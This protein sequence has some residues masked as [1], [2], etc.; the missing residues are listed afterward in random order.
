[1]DRNALRPVSLPAEGTLLPNPNGT[2]PTDR[3]L[4]DPDFDRFEREQYQGG[5]DLE[6]RLTDKTLFRQKLQFTSVDQHENFTLTGY[7]WSFLDDQRTVDRYPWDDRNGLDVFGLDNQVLL[8]FGNEMNPHQL[9][10][11]LDYRRVQS[12]WLFLTATMAPIDAYAPVYGNAI[13][14]E[15]V[16]YIDQRQ[17]ENQIGLYLQDQLSIGAWRITTGLRYDFAGG[18]TRER[19]AAT[20]LRQDDEA[21]SGRAALSYVMP[22]G[23]VPY[24]S[25]ATS[26]E[27][28]YGLD[29]NGLP[30]EPTK[31]KQWEAGLKYQPESDAD[32]FLAAAVFDLTRRN[33]LTP[34]PNPPASNPWGQI[35]AGEVR[36]RGVEL[37]AKGAL[38]PGLEF[39]AAY[40]WFDSEITRSNDAT[41]GKPLFFTPKQQASFWLQYAFAGIEGLSLGAGARYRDSVWGLGYEI[42]VPGYTLFDAM[43]SY[44]LPA[45]LVRSGQAELALNL[46]NATDKRYVANCSFYEGCY[47]GERGT[48]NASL[49]YSW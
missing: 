14:D 38:A 16:E 27:P 48:L 2:L 36:I 42:E 18:D 9:L 41:L 13:L 7:D 12:D 5:Y 1:R 4:G 24:L 47:Y 28:E 25:Y 45:T 33:V 35:Q 43:L 8:D 32:L 44:R 39:T 46:R 49:R 19:Y 37:E 23:I 29:S 31:G 22:S 30:F 34:D 40:T 17:D 26:F 21:L 11:G 6:H 20:D 15:F 10:L 3:F